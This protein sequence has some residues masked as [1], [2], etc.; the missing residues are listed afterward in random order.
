MRGRKPSPKPIGAEVFA[1]PGSEVRI[2]PCP[3]DLVDDEVA[4]T[5]WDAVTREMVAKNLYDEDCAHLV[6]LY[7]INRSRFFAA[8]KQFTAA[9]MVIL[10]HQG[11]RIPNPWLVA[12]NMAN[13]RMVK[14]ASELGLT[15]VTRGRATKKAGVTDPFRVEVPEEPKWLGRGPSAARPSTRSPTGRGPTRRP[16][17]RATSLPATSLPA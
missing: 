17:G 6:E 13:D 1:L 7:C 9:D 11:R 4:R 16:A 8:R 2:P 15:P 5:T 14:L 3:D 12:S 10:S